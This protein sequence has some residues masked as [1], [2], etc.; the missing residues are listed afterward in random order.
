HAE[1]P[2]FNDYTTFL[3]EA[4]VDGVVLALPHDLHAP[5]AIQAMEAGKH[6][7]V[8]KPMARNSNE[9]EQMNA[10]AKKTGKTLM[11]AQNWRYTPW[12]RT[13]RH[14]IDSGELGPV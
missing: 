4:E 6:V 12:V 8:E 3:R 9:C 2:I 14:I 11:I 1:V 13:A 10:A 5:L 7:L